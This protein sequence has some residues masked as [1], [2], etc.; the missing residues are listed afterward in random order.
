MKYLRLPSYW[1][2]GWINLGSVFVT[3]AFV[4]GLS[5]CYSAFIG[6]IM[7]DFETTSTIATLG[8]T[9]YFIGL[10]VFSPFVYLMISKKGIKNTI[11]FGL[12]ILAL[13]HFF[14][15][16]VNNIYQFMTC[17][18][19]AISLGTAMSGIIPS[20]TLIDSWFSDNRGKALGISAAGVS[21]GSF[22]LP[23]ITVELVQSFGW[24]NTFLA[25]S[26]FSVVFIIP[27][28]QAVVRDSSKIFEKSE[29]IIP[30]V[31]KPQKSYLD[32][33]RQPVFI[34]LVISCGMGGLA[35]TGVLINFIS[36]ATTKGHQ[37]LEGALLIS[38]LTAGMLIGKI[39]VG[40]ASDKLSASALL[41][42]C[43]L[44]SG[45][46]LC[47]LGYLTGYVLMAIVSLCLGIG[48]GG[49]L[50]LIGIFVGNNYEKLDFA[51]VMGI[52]I[53]GVFIITSMGPPL[54]SILYENSSSYFFVLSTL[55]LLQTS[56]AVVLVLLLY[57]GKI[58]MLR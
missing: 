2:H 17:Y 47:F 56:V 29:S 19:V 7:L 27:L 23:P 10:V 58:V 49:Y 24:R 55:S 4:L 57:V 18:A 45:L 50:P 15:S 38:F 6:P 21:V 26:V 16:R 48:S 54:V 12:I 13:G 30:L 11:L 37:A 32:I 36:I 31:D 41:I 33:V 40:I 9:A 14:I 43:L 53:P 51:K 39:I 35:Y 42:A 44:F 22:I 20:T 52:V 8:Y 34:I 46:S 3:Q 28:V 25:F 5:G 1:D